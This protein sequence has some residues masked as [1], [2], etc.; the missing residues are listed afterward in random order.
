MCG[1]ELY[2]ARELDIS[3]GVRALSVAEV[4]VGDIVAAA[5]TQGAELQLVEEVENIGLETE[6]VVMIAEVESKF[7]GDTIHIL[8]A[9]ATEAVA[10][11]TRN[12]GL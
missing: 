6:K 7:L 5:V 8:V 9:G 2:S 11:D 1:S 4:L 10:A 12:V 3:S